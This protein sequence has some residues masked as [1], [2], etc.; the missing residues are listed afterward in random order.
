LTIFITWK[1][2]VLWSD[3]VS[4]LTIG[5]IYE[6]NSAIVQAPKTLHHFEKNMLGKFA[7]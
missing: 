5:V 2:K 7:D 3:K 4:V 6:E 1:Y